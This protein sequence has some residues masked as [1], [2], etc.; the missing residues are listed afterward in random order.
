MH[1]LCPLPYLPTPQP[2]PGPCCPVQAEPSPLSCT[3]PGSLCTKHSSPRSQFSAQWKR[4][5]RAHFS[6][7]PPP[8][9][10]LRNT[11]TKQG[12]DGCLGNVFQAHKRASSHPPPPP[13]A[14][15]HAGAAQR[16]LSPAARLGLQRPHPSCPADHGLGT[17][18]VAQG[19]SRSQ[20]PHAGCV[21]PRAPAA[22]PPL[23]K[24]SADWQA[25]QTL[26]VAEKLQALGPGVQE[27]ARV[28]GQRARVPQQLGEGSGGLTGSQKSV[29]GITT[30]ADPVPPGAGVGQARWQGSGALGRECHWLPCR[31]RTCGTQSICWEPGLSWGHKGPSQATGHQGRYELGGAPCL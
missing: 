28:W 26:T 3:A 12:T 17:R 25:V 7:W 8:W 2:L 31:G 23:L 18:L 16:P 19:L 1:A 24:G 10:E 13:P 20:L 22:A 5:L 4:F 9:P 27:K 6:R 21:R 15:S 29:L 30:W 11:E 14:A